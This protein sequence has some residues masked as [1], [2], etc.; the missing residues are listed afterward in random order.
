MVRQN[1]V[2]SELSLYD[3]AGLLGLPPLAV[4][5]LARVG[6]LPSTRSAT[7]SVTLR[8]C[9][10]IAWARVWAERLTECTEREETR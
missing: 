9:A 5:Q 6:V 10:L 7:G 3:A 8:R 2:L 4:Y 1:A